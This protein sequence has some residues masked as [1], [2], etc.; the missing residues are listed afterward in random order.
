LPGATEVWNSFAPFKEKFHAWLALCKRCWTADH[1]LRR[2]LLTHA[3][4][5][6]CVVEDETL[7]HLS[8]Q[9]PFAVSIWIGV[10]LRLGFDIP[11]PS[12]NSTLVNWWPDAVANLSRSNRKI[13]NSIIMLTLRALWLERNARVF[14]Q[15]NSPTAR[16]LDGIVELWNVWV[17]SRRRGGSPGDVT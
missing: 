16:V 1:L 14:D 13:A 11:A 2:G 8:L 4:C 7:D 9:C 15:A 17:S 5:P 12:S 6:L 3:L 10:C